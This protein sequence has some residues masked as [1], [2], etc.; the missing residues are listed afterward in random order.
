MSVQEGLRGWLAERVFGVGAGHDAKR[1]YTHHL[2]PPSHAHTTPRTHADIPY[3][4]G[5]CAISDRKL[6]AGKHTFQFQKV[7]G[8]EDLMISH[9]IWW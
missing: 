3:V 7:E 2:S 4:E 1:S 5:P 6:P 8:P 9:L